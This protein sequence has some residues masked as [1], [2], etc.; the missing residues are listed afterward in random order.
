MKKFVLT[1]LILVFI[2]L[3][4]L[5]QEKALV[6]ADKMYDNRDYVGAINL[7]KKALRKTVDFTEQQQIA[8]RIAMSYFNMNDYIN[9]SDWFEDA[10]GDHSNNIES[11]FTYAQAL[12]VQMKY[13]EAKNILERA[14]KQYPV[15]KEIDTR[16]AAINLIWNSMAGDTLDIVTLVPIINSEY[17][18]YSI[19]TWN[20]GIVFS[21]TRKEKVNQR[22][23]GRTGYGFSDLYYTK[24]DNLKQK[25]SVPDVMSNKLNT[26]FNDGAFTFDSI[27]N[28]AFWTTCSEKPGSCLIYTSEYIPSTQK[29]TK[30]TKVSFMNPKFS[31]GHPNIS[32]DGSTLYFTSNIPGGYGK[33][34]IWKIKKKTDGIWGIP[35]NL[36][37]NINTAKNDMFPSV[38]GDTLLFYSTDGLNTFGGL[39][40]Y[41]S[42]KRGLTFLTPVNL[43]LPVNSAADDFSLLISNFGDGGYFCSNRNINTSDDI[44]HFKGFPIKIVVV[45]NVFHEI[46]SSPI[47]NALLIATNEDGKSDTIFT[48]EEGKYTIKLDAYRKYRISVFK[49][50]YFK[51][52]KIISTSNNQLIFASVPQLKVDYYLSKK[53]YPC[54]IKGVVSNKESYEPMPGV[55]VEISNN[56]GYSTYLHTETNG[57][58]IFEGLKPNTIYTIKTGKNGY[59]TESRVCTLPKVQGATVFSK[60]NGYDMDFQLLQIQTKEEVTLNNIYYDY[61][62]ATLRQTSKIELN[63]LASMIIETPNVIIQINAHTDSRG[64]KEY[65]LKLSADRANSVVNYLISKGV[66]RNRL[67]AK[68][69]GE[70]MLLIKNATS[71]D[72]HQAN[73]RTTFKVVDDSSKLDTGANDI[74]T[75]LVYRIQ[76]MSTGKIKNLNTDF[77]DI[78]HN[79]VN[80]DIFQIDAGSIYKYEVG[81]RFTFSDATALKESLRSLGYSDCFVVSYHKNEKIPVSQAR[82]MEGGELFD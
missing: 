12:V 38:Y 59:F 26:L 15:N 11:Y 16:I 48:N 82:K 42:I 44:Y 75:T 29:W 33:N 55:K 62:K 58:Y 8:H 46:D 36:G 54:G 50:G 6:N 53:S 17:S 3:S 40:I 77:I 35:V 79:I 65:N 78:K 80:V 23:D 18:D 31:Y 47:K 5:A 28:I 67:I 74:E 70:R 60:S 13:L 39:D 10:I 2:V 56:L 24:F 72:E 25:W 49:K 73:R 68:G 43:G 64:R 61:N 51:E 45:G 1:Y 63:K 57:E 9:A 37:E 22:T 7:Y 4:T 41:F 21:S 19:G 32:E 71:E 34:D 14:S 76:I 20:G 52:E 69:Y 30:P 81:N 66:D 27:N